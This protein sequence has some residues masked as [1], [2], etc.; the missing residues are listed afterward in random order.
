MKSVRTK[1]MVVSLLVFLP[2]IITVL[3]AYSTFNQMGD[4]GVAINLSGS[5]RMRTMLISNYALQ[6][7]SDE[8]STGDASNAQKL[9]SAEL[10]KYIKILD[11]L[12]SGDETFSISK[13]EDQKIVDAIKVVRSKTDIYAES[14]N[15]VLLGTADLTDM[16]YIT[17]NALTIKNEI[18][19]IVGMYQSNYDKKVSDFKLTL[20]FLIGFGIVIIV[21]GNIYA[22]NKIV[23]P[24]LKM[25]GILKDIAEGDGDLTKRVN[26]KS[27][28]EIG[29]MANY[30]NQFADSVHKIVSSAKA[31]ANETLES[32]TY[33]TTIL[34]QL[35]LSSEEVAHATTDVAEGAN[36]QNEDATT[37]MHDILENNKH[38]SYGL[39]NIVDTETM[40][41][42]A[43]ISSELGVLAIKEAVDQFDSITRTIEFARDSIEKLNKRTGEIENIVSL[44]S[45]I[46]S[47]TNLLALN[48]SIE[49]ARA[50]EHGTGFAVVANEVRK[51]AEETDDATN[52]IASLITDIQA[53]TSI[54]VNTMNSNVTNVSDQIHIIEKGNQALADINLS[55]KASSIKISEL[56]GIFNF[57]SS[58][59]DNISKSFE[60]MIE[61]IAIT[62]S[63][64]EEVAAAVQEQVASIEEVTSLMETLTG[65]SEKLSGEMNR[66]IL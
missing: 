5:E 9:L 28:D 57:I 18:H 2:F 14:A 50:G 53:E 15:K 19:E 51:L 42:E 23:K 66:F 38:V 36:T 40:S 32:T 27:K 20:V 26:I 46:S 33:V 1:L 65:S 6:L 13:N 61:V 59:T 45:G 37:I 35:T 16:K 54:N 12:V 58:G 29:V 55:V 3:L 48:A 21:I 39:Q 56:A 64:S 63:S 25:T 24:I 49:A 43:L 11:A 22:T 8:D 10:P 44:I 34:H 62:S 60:S 41:K 30:F 4:D 31:I 17:D 52:Q 7:F 47:Q